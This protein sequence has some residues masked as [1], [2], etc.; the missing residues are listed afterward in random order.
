M[1]KTQNVTIKGTKDGLLL[2]L[3]DTCSFS[4][5]L[6]EVEEKLFSHSKLIDDSHEVSV[7]IHTGNRLLSEDQEK[8][9]RDL[10]SPEKK[11]V[12]ASIDSN[13]IL[14]EEANRIKKERGLTIVSTIVRSGQ[15]LNIIGDLLL[16]GDVNPGGKVMASGN[17]FILGRLKG[18]AHAGTNGDEEAVICAAMMSPTQIR[19]ADCFGRS[20]DQDEVSE[21]SECAYINHERQLVIDRLPVL[22]RIRPNINRFVEGGLS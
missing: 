14:K 19:I 10:L 15:V 17:I 4:D 3:D 9:L 8:R 22:K 18:M 1:I 16:I 2:R 20:P 11:L 6:K 5:L 12:I 21:E 13:V 7:R